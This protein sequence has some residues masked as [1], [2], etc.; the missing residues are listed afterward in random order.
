MIN[1]HYGHFCH[2]GLLGTMVLFGAP[3]KLIFGF[4]RTLDIFLLCLH[5]ILE[6]ALSK[7]KMD[8]FFAECRA[9][10]N[11]GLI[12]FGNVCIWWAS[13]PF[14]LYSLQFSFFLEFM[15]AA[16]KQ[17]Y[18]PLFF[19]L[20]QITKKAKILSCSEIRWISLFGIDKSS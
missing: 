2:F 18:W 9:S 12:P 8:R 4:F 3:L 13:P 20:S 16:V 6:S 5:L 14:F 10:E 19:G 7:G 15:T 1:Y 17:V 11:R